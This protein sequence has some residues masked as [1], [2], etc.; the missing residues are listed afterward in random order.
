M[1]LHCPQCG[2]D[3]HGASGP[4]CP[5]CGAVF[6]PSVIVARIRTAQLSRSGFALRMCQ[7][8]LIGL[9][10]GSHKLFSRDLLEPGLFTTCAGVGI[11]AAFLVLVANT[12]DLAW[13]LRYTRTAALG[14]RP[15]S[16]IAGYL[17]MVALAVG[18]ILLYFVFSFIL[19]YVM[20]FLVSLSTVANTAA[21]TERC[22]HLPTL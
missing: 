6:H 22:V 1:H 12:Y 11:P 20:S 19:A 21:I 9:V 16:T 8:A 3:L 4:H 18:Q 10:T 5:E 13:R 14:K 7:P 2:Y 15:Y 17:H